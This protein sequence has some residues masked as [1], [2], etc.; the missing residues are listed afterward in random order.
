MLAWI[1]IFFF[2]YGDD[3]TNKSPSTEAIISARKKRK[4]DL[5]FLPVFVTF[6]GNVF[7]LQTTKGFYSIG[8]QCLVFIDTKALIHLDINFEQKSIPQIFPILASPKFS[9]WV[10][11]L[12]SSLS[13]SFV[14][15]LLSLW[16]L[17]LSYL[18][19]FNHTPSV[20]NHNFNI[21]SF[22][23][24]CDPYWIRKQSCPRSTNMLP[25]LFPPCN[26]I[27]SRSG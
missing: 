4:C 7:W 13:V 20:L 23:V 19:I 3:C 12:T 14:P 22:L 1:L 21:V 17:L 26:V 18:S 25:T 10:I 24:G 2:P 16:S 27:Q 6:L 5:T 15:L 9:G 8:F 11:F